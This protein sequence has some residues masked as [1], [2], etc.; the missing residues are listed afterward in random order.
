MKPLARGLPAGR[1]VAVII[2]ALLTA[3]ADSLQRRAPGRTPAAS[4]PACA[5]TYERRFIPSGSGARSK[6][7]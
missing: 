7:R 6:W 3:S 2:V 1:L 5:S 4:T